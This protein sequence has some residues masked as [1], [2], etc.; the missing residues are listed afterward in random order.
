MDG[1]LF[2]FFDNL[3]WTDFCFVSMDGFLVCFFV[4]CYVLF[5]FV[6]PLFH[7]LGRFLADEPV[8][9]MGSWQGCL[10]NTTPETHLFS[11]LLGLFLVICC[12]L[13]GNLPVVESLEI[14]ILLVPT[15]SHSISTKKPNFRAYSFFGGRHMGAKSRKTAIWPQWLEWIIPEPWAKRLSWLVDLLGISNQTG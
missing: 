2:C 10:R 12:F 15:C 7:P 13:M 4:N 8:W 11:M 6:V 9:L 14:L 3:W 5:I 1:F